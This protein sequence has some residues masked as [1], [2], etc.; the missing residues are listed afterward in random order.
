MGVLQIFRTP[1]PRDFSGWLL[2]SANEFFSTN[3]HHKANF[4]DVNSKIR[5]MQNT[6]Y[7][8]FRK[9]MAIEQC[10]KMNSRDN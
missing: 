8:T 5:D 9:P 7:I 3:I 6:I 2:W 4:E 10:L 1:F